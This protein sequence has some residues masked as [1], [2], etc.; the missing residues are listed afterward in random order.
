MV[1]KAL[2]EEPEEIK[3][4]VKSPDN[5]TENMMVTDNK[6]GTFSLKHEGKLEGKYEI[7]VSH[8]KPGIELETRKVEGTPIIVT[9][10]PEKGL[11][12]TIGTK[13]NGEGQLSDP[14]GVTMTKKRHLLVCDSDNK[15]LQEFSVYGEHR[16]I[17]NFTG[18]RGQVTPCFACVAEDGTIFV[19]D[20]EN[21]RVV[22]CDE[23]GKVI[24]SFGE[25]DLKEPQGIAIHPSNGRVYVLD[26]K[27][28]DVKI[29]NKDGKLLKSFGGN[30]SAPGQLNQPY[31]LTTDREGNIVIPDT[32][33]HRVQ[34]FN[35]DGDCLRSFGKKGS[36]DGQ[37]DRPEDVVQDKDGNF[38]I[39]ERSTSNSRVQK[40]TNTGR[41]LYRLDTLEDH[42]VRPLGLCF[43]K[44]ELFSRV[45]VAGTDYIK[46]FAD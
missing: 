21:I 43:V 25:E 36:G 12:R 13:G 22:V 15:R 37:F 14:Y 16:R 31:G 9:V 38:I 40:F 4:E 19:T 7:S 10:I 39:S 33:N 41:F 28:S 6:D 23:S 44:G 46:V 29:Y 8:H 30:G 45:V 17:I 5:K 34:I 32:H 42:L 35:A 2:E 11:I 3:A 26:H 24:R 18:I 1:K 27:A 20:S